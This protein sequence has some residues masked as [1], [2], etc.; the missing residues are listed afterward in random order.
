MLFTFVLVFTTEDGRS[1]TSFYLL[2]CKSSIWFTEQ[3]I[4]KIIIYFLIHTSKCAAYYVISFE[5]YDGIKILKLWRQE[6]LPFGP[7]WSANITRIRLWTFRLPWSLSKIYFSL[8]LCLL[9][10]C[11]GLVLHLAGTWANWVETPNT[12]AW[13]RRANWILEDLRAPPGMNT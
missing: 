10:Q 11:A 5:V 7:G 2:L 3:H 9:S 13:L 4:L 6:S 8:V 12:A 1:L